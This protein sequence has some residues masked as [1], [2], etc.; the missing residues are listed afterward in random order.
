MGFFCVIKQHLDDQR[1]GLVFGQANP[2]HFWRID[3]DYFELTN[4][5]QLPGPQLNQKSSN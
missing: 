3:D 5:Y 4:S 2:G 1:L